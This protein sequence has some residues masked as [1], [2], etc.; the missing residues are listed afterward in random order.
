MRT[1]DRVPEAGADLLSSALRRPSRNRA[2]SRS[3]WL[4]QLSLAAGVV[5]ISLVGAIIIPDIYSYVPFVIGSLMIAA[6]TILTMGLPWRRLPARAVLVIPLLDIVAIGLISYG[7]VYRL[8]YL[9]VFPIAWVATY[10]SLRWLVAAIGT[11]TVLL[12][13]DAFTFA[14]APMTIQRLLVIV[15]SLS[16]LG[17][18]IY[19]VARNARALRSLLSRQADRLR[20]TLDRTREQADRTTQ[21]FDSLDVA[22]ARVS[23]QGEILA[24]N[25]AYR[26][27]YALDAN[28]LSL[29][30]GSVEYDSE[31]GD[32]LAASDRPIA[33]AARGELTDGERSWLYDPEGNWHVLTVSTRPLSAGD[34]VRSTVLI[35]QDVSEL[36]RAELERK[37][38]AA[39]VSHELRNPL[40]AALAHTELLLERDDLPARA[41]EQIALIEAAGERMLH[42][43]TQTIEN[44]SPS[45]PERLERTPVNVRRV[46]DASIE[47]FTPAVTA[48]GVRLTLEAPTEIM[49]DADAFRLR[50]VFDNLLTNAVKY[51]RADDRVS[52]T[53][54]ADT[55]AV[56]VDIADTGIGIDS[57]ELPRIFEP[58]YRAQ[59]ARESG[60]IGNGIG[61][62]VVKEIVEEHGGA[63]EV[64]SALGRGTTVKLKLPRHISGGE[65]DART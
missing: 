62:G 15:L 39:T 1:L 18:C 20:Q 32:A 48:A 45:E 47:S 12:T 40:T 17:L 19:S 60:V 8:S 31:R 9:W 65:P 26:E 61:M 23:S 56:R 30:G 22:V 4:W 28:D 63:I 11:V 16:F 50:Q 13:I 38:L 37:T 36:H 34:G 43:V 53:A 24:V 54:H 59:S 51:S 49:V 6:I 41:R 44:T 35:V 64:T 55:T 52:I 58:Y 46:L 21:M 3:I 5:T 29:P 57:S 2:R 10:Y 7:G 27:L 42:L 33:R 25:E 14:A